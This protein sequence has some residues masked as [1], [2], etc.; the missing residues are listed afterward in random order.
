M[1]LVR[2]LTVLVVVAVVAAGAVALH[3]ASDPRLCDVLRR[4]QAL[5]GTGLAEESTGYGLVLCKWR[6]G[7]RAVLAHI[8]AF[9]STTEA[10]AWAADDQHRSVDSPSL[11]VG[12]DS[13][14]AQISDDIVTAVAAESV[15]VISV[16]AIGLGIEG[17]S[18]A[19]RI[20][21]RVAGALANG[22]RPWS[23]G[24]QPGLFFE[25]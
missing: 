10:R 13:F 21:E 18:A 7:D 2:Y 12:D 8:L 11:G 23:S 20:V 1:P 14:A 24:D 19:R 15:Y 6:D 25:L 9:A 5:S 17:P 3:S 22:W 16:D 4:D